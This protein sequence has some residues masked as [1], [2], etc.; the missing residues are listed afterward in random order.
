MCTLE[1]CIDYP[2]SEYINAVEVHVVPS[3]INVISA[4]CT[5]FYRGCFM[6]LAL[7]MFAL[8]ACVCMNDLVVDDQRHC[9]Y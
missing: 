9:E 2:E 4:W 8:V 1:A 5:F 3:L 7:R 6:C